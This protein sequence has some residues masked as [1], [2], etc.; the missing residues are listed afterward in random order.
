MP[1]AG[2]Y[3][4]I[5]IPISNCIYSGLNRMFVLTQF[6]SVSLHRHIANTYKFDPFG[7]GFVEILAAQQTMENEE[8]YQGTADAVRQ[9]IP[10]FDQEDN[11][12]V[13]ILSGDQLYRMDFQDMIRP[14][15]RDQGRRDDRRPAGRRGGGDR[16]R[17]HADRA[18][19]P[20]Q[21]LRR[22]AQDPRA[23]WPPS[24]PTRPG[25]RPAGIRAG[26]RAYLA[27]MGIYLFNRE[28]LVDLLDEGRR[29]TTSARASSR[30]RSATRSSGSRSSRSTATGR[31]SAPSAPSTRPTST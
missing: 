11:D 22:E 2:K 21:Q 26:N 13:L 25:S 27:S 8:W 7:G 23:P 20:G 24:G 18:R 30:T 17:D 15:L 28:V 14:H 16:L 5:D 19:R 1:I 4:L 3:R 29:R 31:T 12:L 9:N 10:Y 6:N